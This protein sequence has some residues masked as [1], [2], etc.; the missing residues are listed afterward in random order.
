MPSAQ[1][2]PRA[3]ERIRPTPP[4][5]PPRAFVDALLGERSA[6]WLALAVLLVR[7]PGFHSAI[8]NIDECDHVIIARLMRVGVLP[9]VGV[10]EIKPPLTYALFWAASF[11]GHSVLPARV[12]TAA[13]LLGTILLV[14]GAVR[15]WTGDGRAAA[16]AGWAT[17]VANLCELPWAA[18]EVLMNLPAAAAIYFFV[19]SETSGNRRH[20]LAAGIAIGAASLFKHQAGILLPALCLGLTWSALGRG[21]PGLTAWRCALLALGFA[22]PWAAAAG[23]YARL[24]HL[25]EFLEWVVSRNFGYVGTA[26]SAIWSRAGAVAFAV[27]GG[28]ALWWLA[29]SE[30][31]KRRRDPIGFTLALALA[32]TWIPVSLGGRFYQH[33]FLQFAPLLGALSGAGLAQ[34]LD[35]WRDMARRRR[36]VFGALLALPWIAYASYGLARAAL[37]DYPFQEPRAGQVAAWLHEHTAPQDRVFVWGH[38]TPIYYQSDRLPGTRYLMTSVHMG[39]FDP[40]ELP[41]GF[42]ITPW[43][44]E[45]DVRATL[46]DLEANRTAWVVDTAPADIHSWSQIPLHKF[47]ELEGYI[48]RHYVPVAVAGGAT[49]YRRL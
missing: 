11:L 38:F 37:R 20:D 9:Y 32:L 46:A 28:A 12:L 4:P 8:L 23:I 10:V 24:G 2:A 49:I 34:L 19:R 27:G 36:A 41:P 47:P 29:G 31:L 40:G 17:L 35:T 39:N 7:L 25:P 5:P 18:T 44:S 16:A 22:L 21:R 48:S 1:P 30:A 45:R 26:H 3:L 33:Y 13:F 15:R 43:R 6:A 14:R 42:D